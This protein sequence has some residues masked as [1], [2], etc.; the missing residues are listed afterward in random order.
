MTNEKS[1]LDL[2]STAQRDSESVPIS[3]EVMESIRKNPKAAIA[4]AGEVSGE[5]HEVLKQ[6][7]SKVESKIAWA[8][9]ELPSRGMFG[10]SDSKSIEIRPFTFE[11][12]KILRNIKNVGAAG[13]VINT[14][15]KRCTKDL[16][17]A[18]LPLVDKNFIL[19]KLRE[20][21]YGN[22]Y[23]IEATCGDC[24]NVNGL[25]VSL[26]Q[27]PI[28]YAEEDSI[29]TEVL[30]PDSEVTVV[31]KVPTTQDEAYLSDVESLMDNLW[32]L[33][34]SIDG[35][36]E[37]IITQG[38]IMG[39]TAKDITVLRTAIMDMELG[40]QTQVHYICNQCQADSNVEL[41]INESFFGV[42]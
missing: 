32:R 5:H 27:L 20:I 29:S 37:R 22:D 35:H 31:F 41:P 34:K 7:L 10:D 40:I 25:V 18:T 33:V 14:L 11:D 9:V 4:E 2:A 26:N 36:T 3:S 12:E 30:L 42:S 17:F 19:Y 6:L 8:T 24:A 23:K 38:F 21:S 15:I 39:S 1:I 28:V 16:N 13:Q